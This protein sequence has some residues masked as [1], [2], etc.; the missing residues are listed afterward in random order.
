MIEESPEFDTLSE[1]FAYIAPLP[2]RHLRIAKWRGKW[3]A[4]CLQL[5][6]HCVGQ[7]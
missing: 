3:S 5:T 7:A 2:W 4:I 6:G 1:L